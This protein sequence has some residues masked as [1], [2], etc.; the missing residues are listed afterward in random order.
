MESSFGGGLTGVLLEEGG[1]IAGKVGASLGGG[2]AE[3]CFWEGVAGAPFGEEG[4]TAGRGVSLGNVVAELPLR[5]GGVMAR[6]VGASVGEGVAGAPLE[7]EGVTARGVRV[8]LGD[9][10]AGP[11]LGE[12]AIG[13]ATGASLGDGGVGE[14]FSASD[15]LET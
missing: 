12:G 7:V 6:G 9:G 3:V 15:P 5:E 13:G 2:V 8:S 11:S 1:A 10:D 4:V 14:C